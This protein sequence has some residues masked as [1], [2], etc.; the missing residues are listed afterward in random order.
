M[1]KVS[2]FIPILN[3]EEILQR[4]V[5][6]IETV[7]KRLPQDFEIFV[8]D[9]ASND[10]SA[11]IAQKIAKSNR[12]VSHLR[13]ELGPTRRE[14]LAQAF[15]NANGDIVAFMDIDLATDL[16][17]VSDLINK[18]V[19]EDY[20]IVIG[21]RYVKGSKIKR[22][23]F[24]LIISKMYNAWIRMLFKTQIMD[25]E[26][27]FKAFKRDVILKLVE[28]MGYDKT[29]RRGVFWDTE[30]LVRATHHRYKI[31]EIPVIWTERKKSA[32]N[33]RREIKSLGYIFEFKRRW[34]NNSNHDF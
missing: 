28:E 33:F 2:M 19:Q 11:I 20:D 27:G 15:K 29:L 18:V 6:L 5:E 22:K 12:R 34:K 10:N 9:D 17:C 24:R 30:F 4:D 14:N 16:N 3:E 25:H 23:L 32:L 1:N 8:V 13:F 26:C 31:K 21:S 7:L